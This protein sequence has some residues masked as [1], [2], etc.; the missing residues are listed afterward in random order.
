[1][2]T[3]VLVCFLAVVLCAAGVPI[4]EAE[5][6]ASA[7]NVPSADSFVDDFDSLLE[8]Q[9]V[10]DATAQSEAAAL[11]A[12]QA[13]LASQAVAATSQAQA[14]AEAA[15]AALAAAAAKVAAGTKA[16]ASSNANARRASDQFLHSD[17]ND[18]RL[19]AMV[20]AVKDAI[21]S[22]RKSCSTKAPGGKVRSVRVLSARHQLVS[23]GDRKYELEVESIDAH[24]FLQIFIANVRWRHVNDEHLLSVD[25]KLVAERAQIVSMVPRPCA[26]GDAATLIATSAQVDDINA[27]NLPWTAAL[28]SKFRGKTKAEMSNFFGY[29][30]DLK[31]AQLAADTKSSTLGVV[32]PEAYDARDTRTHE[33]ACVAFQPQDQGACGSG[34]VFGSVSPVAARLCMSSQRSINFDLS[35]QEAME[36]TNGCEG[37]FEEDVY[38]KMY[39]KPLVPAACEP[40]SGVYNE[41]QCGVNSCAKTFEVFIEEDSIRRYTGVPAMQEDLL[42]NGPAP[43][44]FEAFDD[45]FAYRCV[46]FRVYG[47]ACMFMHPPNPFSH[48]QQRWSIH[49]I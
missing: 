49:Q 42:V 23:R 37:G 28:N 17:P 22:G 43:V 35:F 41:N 25:G 15:A 11:A 3:L 9:E 27:Q 36:C 40:Y 26:V 16:A 48:Q 45:F 20:N 8:S 12:A 19:P 30:P 4:A 46:R 24:G 2:K 32:L 18:Q 13:E 38:T 34:Y 14:E 31:L 5:D 39:T 29:K 10:T 1:M 33:A 6:P 21:D 44:Y 47:V 7:A